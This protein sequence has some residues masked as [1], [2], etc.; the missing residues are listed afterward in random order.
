MKNDTLLNNIAYSKLMVLPKID[1]V[2]VFQTHLYYLA[3]FVRGKISNFLL[4]R[5]F[6]NSLDPIWNESYR[7]E[8]CHSAECLDFEVR[9]K[10]HAYAEFIGV[11]TIPVSG[12]LQVCDK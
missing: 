11:V 2:V 4:N 12:G 1:V 9:D 6:L 8:V 5:V 3:K 7:I 10:D